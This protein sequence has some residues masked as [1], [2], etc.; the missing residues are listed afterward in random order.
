MA[1]SREQNRFF[2]RSCCGLRSIA[3][4]ILRILCLESYICTFQAVI[5]DIEQILGVAVV[6]EELLQ[7]LSEDEDQKQELSDQKALTAD[8]DRVKAVSI[9]QER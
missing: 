7:K 3:S 2:L 8:G 5:K 1:G 9:I 6:N 4:R